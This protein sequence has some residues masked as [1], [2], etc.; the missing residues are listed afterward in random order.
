MGFQVL[1]YEILFIN[2]YTYLNNKGY[3]IPKV[4]SILVLMSEHDNSLKS[5][6]FWGINMGVRGPPSS[7]N[8]H[9]VLL[10][11]NPEFII[12]N[13]FLKELVMLSTYV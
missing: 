2:Y 8:S 12:L 9:F 10:T 4:Q 7:V 5:A 11:H 1:I 6:V 13:G 3:V